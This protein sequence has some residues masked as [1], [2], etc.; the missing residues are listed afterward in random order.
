MMGRKLTLVVTLV[1]ISLTGTLSACGRGAKELPPPPPTGTPTKGA[2]EIM[3]REGDTSTISLESNPTTGYQ[4]YVEFPRTHLELVEQRYEPDSRL[5]G[6]GGREFFTFRAL[7][8]GLIEIPF[9]YKRAWEDEPFRTERYIFNIGVDP[10][11]QMS[12]SEAREIAKNSECVKEGALKETA[13]YND[14][15]GT[16][17]I[18]LDIE[19]EGCSPACVVDVKTKQVEINHRCTGGLPPPGQ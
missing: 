4:W 11:L 17:W 13:Y 9:S 18:D 2:I 12:L 5:V 6:G 7:E 1:V 15:T 10:A 3:L 8:R 14:W 19:M 16:W